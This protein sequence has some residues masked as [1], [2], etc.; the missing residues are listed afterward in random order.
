MDDI[1]WEQ[2]GYPTAELTS[3]KADADKFTEYYSC[4]EV[5]D[6]QTGRVVYRTTRPPMGSGSKRRR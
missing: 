2:I 4:V 1:S 6:Q 5:R 3:A